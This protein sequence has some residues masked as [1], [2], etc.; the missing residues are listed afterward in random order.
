M[1]RFILFVLALSG[2]TKSFAQD[3]PD[4]RWELG[5]RAGVSTTSLPTGPDVYYTGTKSSWNGNYAAN[6]QY[7]ITDKWQ[8]G[9]DMSWSNWSTSGSWMQSGTNGQLAKPVTVT[10]VLAQPS[11]SFMGR[12]N[13]LIPFRDAY[14][15]YNKA[16]IYYG[17]ALGMQTANND[18][19]S[20]YNT[21][22]EPGSNNNSSYHYGSGIGYSAGVQIGFDY[23]IWPNLGINIEAAAREAYIW[24]N[25][26]RLNGMN[27]EYNIFYFPITAG[28]K[29][30]F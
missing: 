16:N 17:I 21:L 19:N 1:K 14:T 20:A 28:I 26:S 24:T 13:R 22:S 29:Y 9:I 6:I 2:F 12:F 11:V 18:A 23:Y 25:D 27:S 5:V 3:L 10:F 7:N 15:E 4:F 30:R 8:A